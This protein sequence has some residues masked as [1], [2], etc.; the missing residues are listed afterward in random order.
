MYKTV[1]QVLHSFWCCWLGIKLAMPTCCVCTHMHTFSYSYLY[2]EV[3]C[4]ML[5][6]S[7]DSNTFKLCKSN[8]AQT[9]GL[10]PWSAAMNFSCKT[11]SGASPSISKFRDLAAFSVRRDCQ[12]VLFSHSREHLLWT[13]AAPLAGGGFSIHSYLRGHKGQ[14]LCIAAPDS[15]V[16][17]MRGLR[18]PKYVKTVL[19]CVRTHHW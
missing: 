13:M 9:T 7:L 1:P 19:G 18:P 17:C 5:G 3:D 6:S 12:L 14:V 4:R 15:K 2:G 10:K 16:K 8:V 11:S